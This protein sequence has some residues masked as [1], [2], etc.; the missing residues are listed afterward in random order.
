LPRFSSRRASPALAVA[1]LALL[2]ALSGTGIAATGLITGKQIKN[3]TITGIDIRN[4]SLGLGDLSKVTVRALGEEAEGVP[5]VA[6]PGLVAPAQLDNDLVSEASG[7]KNA[8]A[9]VTTTRDGQL[10]LVK[11]FASELLCNLGT[12]NV[13]WWLTLD[14]VPVRSTLTLAYSGRGDLH[15]TTLAGVTDGSVKAGSHVLGIG[16]MCATSSPARPFTF[17]GSGGSAIVLG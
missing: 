8:D 11:S 14:G 7:A 10:L 12:D 1:S 4:G 17:L 9:T 6:S 3:G 16:A 15:P 2:V 5:A 13:W